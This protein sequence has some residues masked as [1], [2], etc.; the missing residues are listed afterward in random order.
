[1]AIFMPV[2][3]PVGSAACRGIDPTY[4]TRPA[5]AVSFTTAFFRSWQPDSAS[6]FPGAIKTIA[7]T[8]AGLARIFPDL[9]IGYS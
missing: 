2:A 3:S 9:S 8:S 6:R 5:I 7:Q 1:M 4:L